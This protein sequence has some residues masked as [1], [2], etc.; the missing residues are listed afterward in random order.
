MNTIDWVAR[1]LVI[2]GALNWG[3]GAFNDGG[4]VLGGLG[5]VTTIIY[6]LVGLAGIWELIALFKK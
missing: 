3:I 4:G 2:I 5:I 6:A 1:I